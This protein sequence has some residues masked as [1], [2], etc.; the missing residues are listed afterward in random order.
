MIA[1]IEIYNK[2]NFE[3]REETFS[4]LCVNAWELLIKARWLKLNDNKMNSLYVYESKTNI[5]GLKSKKKTIKQ[6]RSGNAFTHSV[7]YLAEQLMSEKYLDPIAWDNLQAM[8]EI[9]DNSVHFY[10]KSY[11]LASRLQEVGSAAVKNFV[12]ATKE[13]FDVDMSKYN[14][15][16]MPLSFVNPPAVVEGIVLSKEEQNIVRFIDSKDKGNTANKA[17]SVTVNVNISF[18]RSK[19]REALEF[20]MTND[21][22]APKLYLSEQQI[23]EKYK[24]N[25]DALTS[26]CRSR[27]EDFKVNSTYHN[28]RKPLEDDL[29]YAMIRLLDPSNPSGVKKKYYS[30]AV[31]TKLD[32]IYKKRRLR[33]K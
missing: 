11:L 6:T 5:D 23:D 25:Y 3:Y 4:V 22:S 12:T 1:A 20:Q 17:Y 14:F 30:E 13:W 21:P 32:A 31:L 7:D 16:L 8:I 28:A 10:N 15:F 18:S 29:K 27:Y 24:Y 9:R 19:V 2:P 26:V 33:D